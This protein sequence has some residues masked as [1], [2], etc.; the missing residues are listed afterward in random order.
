MIFTEAQLQQFAPETRP[1][2]RKLSN[3]Y[4]VLKGF[5]H[6]TDDFFVNAPNIVG[7]VFTAMDHMLYFRNTSVL[8]KFGS[9][10][11]TLLKRAQTNI[12]RKSGA[13]LLEMEIR[14]EIDHYQCLLWVTS[15]N[16][17]PAMELGRRPG[18]TT[19]R[20]KFIMDTHPHAIEM[21][22]D[23]SAE[24]IQRAE[25]VADLVDKAIAE[26]G[27]FYWMDEEFMHIV[28]RYD[29]IKAQHDDLF[30]TTR[31]LSKA[32]NLREKC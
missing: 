20:A 23:L 32:Q 31:M 15:N 11:E 19:N 2:L 5:T 29:E 21:T 1:V 24:L 30:L 12:I 25:G 14:R 7:G 16:C 10:A 28:R 8:G 13:E 17:N 18:A 9:Y 4:E 3:R 27:P 22:R 26:I 6:R